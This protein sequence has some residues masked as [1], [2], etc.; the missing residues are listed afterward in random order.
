MQ[1]GLLKYLKDVLYVP[2]ITNNLVLVGQM[3]EQGLQVAF[4]LNGCFVENMK[5]QGK[6]IAKGKWNGRMFTL[7]VN[8]DEMNFMLFTHG[9]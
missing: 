5:N 3:A 8:M 1:D 7:D 4:N 2:T 6:L 9:K